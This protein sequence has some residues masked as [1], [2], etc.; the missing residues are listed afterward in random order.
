MLRQEYYEE[1]SI[2]ELYRDVLEHLLL[3]LDDEDEK[4]ESLVA[5][6][7]E[8]GLVVHEER[9]RVWPPWPWP[10]WG[11]D[12]DG[13]EPED[14]TERAHRLAKAIIKFEKE[15]AEASLDL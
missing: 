10:P 9:L 7:E 12:D 14:R 15:I 1:E 11:G 5:Q 6:L 8:P 4:L 3:A 13:D 2:V